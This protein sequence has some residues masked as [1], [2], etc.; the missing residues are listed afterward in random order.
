[1]IV[2]SDGTLPNYSYSEGFS[3]FCSDIQQIGKSYSMVEDS[4]EAIAG[5]R[6]GEA[7][8]WKYRY[9]IP[10]PVNFTR[11]ASNLDFFLEPENRPP[12]LIRFYDGFTL[13]SIVDTQE[14]VGSDLCK[15]ITTNDINILDNKLSLLS[16]SN[17]QSGNI[18]FRK[19][20]LGLLRL[21]G[22]FYSDGTLAFHDNK[23]VDFSIQTCRFDKLIVDTIETLNP[24]IF[25]SDTIGSGVEIADTS[26]TGIRFIQSS[27][28]GSY[29]IADAGDS[30]LIFDNCRFTDSFYLTRLKVSN[31]YFSN[32]KSFDKEISIQVDSGGYPIRLYFD[33]NTDV[34]KI[35]FFYD[36]SFSICLNP[37][38]DEDS[39]RKVFEALES[40]FKKEYR[41]ADLQRLQIE[42]SIYEYSR[43][44]YRY[45]VW[46]LDYAW[47]YYGF[48]KWLILV[49]SIGFLLI[50]FCL[51]FRYWNRMTRTYQIFQDR[52]IQR[53]KRSGSGPASIFSTKGYFVLLYTCY[54]FF[55]LKIDF[56]KLEYGDK[57]CLRLF[58]VQWGIGLI[59]LFF[60]VNAIFKIA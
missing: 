11:K 25:Y 3:R 54:V 60:L 23:I 56:D 44:W 39:N 9:T 21:S 30:R 31:L 28:G 7:H 59:C 35:K 46:L 5:L 17:V 16:V 43:S 55:S 18:N 57:K 42:H 58:F 48:K 27:L 2:R 12:Y 36:S 32:C 19:N 4:A 10:F 20:D 29:S 38:Q 41:S 34:D 13:K 24:L 14:Y 1:M 37:Y 45:P 47:W 8:Q 26:V 53:T 40:K 52:V 50:F 49:W 15:L 51:N 6:N 33:A 22:P